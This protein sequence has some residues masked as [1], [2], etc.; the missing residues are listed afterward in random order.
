MISAIIVE[1]EKVSRKVLTEYIKKYCPDIE[2]LGEAGNIDDAQKLIEQN[3]PQLVFLDIEMPKGNGFDLLE[4]F[5]DIN[6]EVI[7]VTAF[8]DYAIQAFNFSAAYYLLKP[9][10]ID[11]LIKSVEKIKHILSEKT[12]WSPTKILLENIQNAIG[13]E[14][15]IALPLL[16]GFEVVKTS[17]IVRCQANDNFTEFYFVNGKKM[18]ICRTLK[19]YEELLKDHGFLRVHKSHLVNKNHIKRYTKGKGGSLTMAD[20]STVDVSSTYK[21]TLQNNFM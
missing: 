9:I 12:Q 13:Q 15:K 18:M 3:K 16:N 4:R 6:F 2:L 1:D 8:N 20:N 10:S 7:F 17:D 19:F 5:K 14:Q 21:D 11:E